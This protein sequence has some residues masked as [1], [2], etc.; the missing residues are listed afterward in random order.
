[1]HRKMYE[2]NFNCRKIF[3]IIYIYIYT[4]WKKI[5]HPKY[6]VELD[7][8]FDFEYRN[9]IIKRRKKRKSKGRKK[10][11]LCKENVYIF[12]WDLSTIFRILFN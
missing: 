2:Y 5:D 9:V 4:P 3:C 12:L 7:N 11:K 8:E 1:M 6:I 10:I